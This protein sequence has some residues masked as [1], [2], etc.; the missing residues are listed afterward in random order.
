MKRPLLSE[1]FK[2]PPRPLSFE[3][4]LGPQDHPIPGHPDARDNMI[5]P[6]LIADYGSTTAR[7]KQMRYIGKSLVAAIKEMHVSARS[8]RA[9]PYSGMQTIDAGTL[10]EL[11][12]YAHSLGVTD[13][14]YT[15]VNTRY[16]FKRFKI[17]FPNAM[18]FTMEMDREKIRQAPSMPS[19][20]EIF[21]TYHQ[22]GVVVNQV[23][24]FLRE[25]GYNA[26]AQPAIGGDINMIPVAIDAGLG[27]SGKNGLLITRANGPRIRLAA[28]LTDIENLPF[29]EENPFHWV[30]DYCETCNNCIHHCPADAIHLE[31]RI[32]PDGGPVFIDYT[33]CAGPFSNDNGCTL[34]IKEC[35]FS[36]AEYDHLKKQFEARH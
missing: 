18:V 34:C 20:I 35:P 2:R 5:V 16:I 6:L 7:M 14:G 12:A 23:A 26:Q 8:V 32:H 22:L 1:R 25:R 24:D 11:E 36:Y 21:R 29:A 3:S 19:F 17:L 15:R 30:R 10:R 31:T 4:Y 28:V 9:N 13:I 27:Y 33:R